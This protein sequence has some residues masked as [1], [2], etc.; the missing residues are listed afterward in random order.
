MP[1]FVIAVDAGGT[2]TRVGCFALD[3]SRLGGATG[4]GGSPNHNHDA[5]ENVAATLA[6]A[7]RNGGLDSTEAVALLAGVAAFVN[8]RDN[9]WAES[10]IRSPGLCCPTK[11]VNDA[12]VAHAGALAGEPGVIVVAGTGSMIAAIT[13]AGEMI[14]SG[15]LQHYAGGARHLVFDAMHRVFTG[16]IGEADATLI[17]EILLYWKASDV[18]Q[19]RRIVLDL[20]A[21]DRNDVKRRYGDLAPLITAAADTSPLADAALRTLTTKTAVGIA[22]LAPL[23]TGVRAPVA[24]AGS[25]ATAPTFVR[26]LDED[27]TLLTAGGDTSGQV[28]EIATTILD[29][30]GG[31][32]LLALEIAGVPRSAELI[33]Q[34]QN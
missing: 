12:V 33:T 22:L 8:G 3:G 16:Q 14:E 26:R 19:L 27:L 6:D 2:H 20:R 31:A 7:L 21:Q 17:G 10:F 15:D 34:L 23:I 25:L 24:L 9:P 29:P 32:A 4:P 5:A 30:V 13:E 18:D 11:I 28:I 1:R